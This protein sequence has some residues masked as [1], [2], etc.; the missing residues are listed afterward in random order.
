[1]KKN[2]HN[3]S[4]LF[5]TF[6]KIG[7]FTFGGG[8]AMIPLLKKELVDKH[9]WIEEE[10]F[11]D[12]IALTQS[13]PGALAINMA[14]FKGHSLFGLTGALIAAIGVSLPSF[15]IISLICIGFTHLNDNQ[16]ISAIFQGIRPAVVALI[17][18]TGY[19]LSKKFN[20]SPFILAVFLFS[21]IG[22]A[23]F[24]ISPVI[25]IIIAAITGLGKSIS[26]NYE[27][28]RVAKEK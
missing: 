3:I 7:I 14:I 27:I 23:F 18:Y 11:L 26:K 5:F 17:A 19:N 20:W 1:L 24:K 10:E 21:L 22:H 9:G 8:F 2:L 12:Y 6:F 16:I 4:K 13:V 25:I 28:I 15:L